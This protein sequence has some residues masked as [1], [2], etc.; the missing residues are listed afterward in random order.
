MTY[1][2][3]LKADFKEASVMNALLWLI[4]IACS[5]IFFTV[6]HQTMEQIDKLEEDKIVLEMSLL[7]C[8]AISLEY[9]LGACTE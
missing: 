8:E 6:Y 4:L 3:K 9:K 7:E 5:V 2:E 1:T